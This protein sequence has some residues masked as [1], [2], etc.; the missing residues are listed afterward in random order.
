MA[1]I[2]KTNGESTASPNPEPR[3]ETDNIIPRLIEDEMKTSY[4]D[5][6]MSVI[7]GRALPDVRDGLKPVHRRILFA[8]NEMGMVHNKPFKKSAR[9][10]G[11]VLGKYHPHGDLAVYD[12]LVRM[13]QDFSL[14]YPLIDGQGN[15]GSVDGD[16][17]AAMRYTECRLSKISEELLTDID[18]ETIDFQPNFDGSLDEPKVLPAKLPNLLINGTSGIAV[19]MATNIPPHNIK[20]VID[21]IIALIDDPDTTIEQLMAYVK[22]PDFPTSGLIQGTAGIKQAY[23]TGRGKVIV[24]SKAEIEPHKDR[25]RIIVTEIPYMVNKAQLIED[26]AGLV[27]DKRIIGISDIRDESDRDG[28]RMV[29]ELRKDANSNVVLNQ[30]FE[31]T[32]LTTSFGMNMVALVDNQPQTLTLKQFMQQY[33]LHRQIVVRRRTAF[34]LKKA[35]ERAHLL[36]GLIIALKHIDEIVQKIKRSKDTEIARAMLMADYSL[37]EPQAKAIL[38]M[39]L[40]RLSSLEQAKIHEEHDELIKTIAELGAILASEPRIFGIIKE[41]LLGLKQ[42]YGDGRKTVIIAQE[43]EDMEVEDLIK[44]ED[45]AVTVSHAGYIKRLPVTTYRQQNRGGTGVKAA[46]TKEADFVEHLFVASTHSSILFFT[47]KGRVHWLK[48]HQIPEASRTAMGKAIVNLLPIGKEEKIAAFVL[49]KAFDETHF[50]TLATKKGTIK[51]TALSE[52]SRPRQGG[53]IAISIDEG[54]DLVGAVLTDGKQQ[55]MLSTLKG[56]AA[57]FHEEDV[58]AMGRAAYGVKGI[59]LR[60]NDKVVSMIIAEDAK[61]VL[62]VCENGY[63]KRTKIEEYRLIRRGGVGVINI[64]ATERNGDVVAVMDVDDEDEIMLIS[65]SGIIIRTPVRGISSIGRNTQGVRLMRLQENDK[66]VAAAKIA[67]EE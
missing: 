10:V 9:I 8:M 50:L 17:A 32:N 16:N 25:E 3:P 61:T 63:G 49:V 26:I 30:L 67:R 39:K 60:D 53:I 54:D 44:E 19:G 37:S 42:Q 51:K 18:K 56:M 31:Y 13:A 6:A 1:K 15:F 22:G 62:T 29:I 14:R 11:E 35:E 24:K 38:D 45:M 43:G 28:M 5:Y 46:T 59:E 40:Q 47:N 65:Q 36:D 23:L 52:Y 48:V 21:G 66:V 64:Q 12:A 27:R 20:E 2:P 41:E 34:E 58:R 7:V 4:L 33:V 57:K 55:L